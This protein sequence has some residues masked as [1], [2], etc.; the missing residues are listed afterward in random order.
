MSG[1]GD[2]KDGD[3][4]NRESARLQVI[5]ARAAPLDLLQMKPSLGSDAVALFLGSRV[6]ETTPK[7]AM[8]YRTAWL[9]SPSTTCPRAPRPSF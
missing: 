8:E 6:T 1:P 2:P 5:V 4:V 7:S 9:A 3:L